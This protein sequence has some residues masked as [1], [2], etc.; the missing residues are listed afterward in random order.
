MTV[1]RVIAILALSGALAG[2]LLMALRGGDPYVLRLE[3]A[4]ANGLIK[5]SPV[6]IGSVDVGKVADLAIGPRGDV[7]ARLELD[8]DRAR[9]GR[10]ARAQVRPSNLLGSKLVEIDPGDR[11]RPLPSGATI[12][13]A[14]VETPV[15]LQDV[16]DVLDSDTRVRLAVLI[17]EAGTALT[18]RRT[19][20]NA[21][22]SR[23]PTSTHS[24]ARLLEQLAGD[25][26]ALAHVVERS[27]G[28]LRAVAGQR[29]DLGRLVHGFAGTFATVAERR[30][31]LRATLRDA[32][33]TLRTLRGFLRELRATT[34]PLGPAARNLRA[35]A[36]PLASTLGAVPGFDVAARPTLATAADVAPHLSLL[37]RDATPALRRAV[38]FLETVSGFAG[39]LRPAS[40]AL[41]L[42]VDDLL[43]TIEGWARAIQQRDGVGHFFRA[44][45]RIAPDL[46][47]SAVD[48]DPETRRR[49]RRSPRP[50][51]PAPTATPLPGVPVPHPAVPAPKVPDVPPL[52]AVPD[53]PLPKLPGAPQV[54]DPAGDGRH[55]ADKLLDYLL[56]S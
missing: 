32:P 25:N 6:T 20:F 14:R 16:F 2:V 46:L 29:R 45:L 31:E 49:A 18:G 41:G 39:D 23:L 52:P 13:P 1:P 3:L 53:V 12:P 38:P 19:D 34:V 8:R 17:N 5:G 54:P 50:G 33:R 28:F 56:G 21:L 15:D 44:D 22:L 47:Q 4:N 24:V 37:A 10:N 27:D 35:S 43:G 30:A 42:S 40:S 48:K 11:A 51:A 7:V 9:V 55:S 36:A 26:R